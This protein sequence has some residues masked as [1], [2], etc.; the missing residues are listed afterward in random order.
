MLI[1]AHLQNGELMLYVRRRAKLSY[2]TPEQFTNEWDYVYANHTPWSMPTQ[3]DIAGNLGW[4]N[5]LF[6]IGLVMLS[7]ITNCYPPL[8]PYPA[9]VYVPPLE[10]AHL[11]DD[12]EDRQGNP[13]ADAAQYVRTRAGGDAPLP[14][15]GWD[16]DR[17]RMSANPAVRAR[18]AEH[19]A[20][21]D[22]RL[23]YDD[24]SGGRSRIPRDWVRVWSWGGFIL[25]DA[26]P[27]YRRID[28]ELRVLVAWCLCDRP[29]YR[30]RLRRLEWEVRG[31]IRRN[32]GDDEDRGDFDDDYDFG[33][34]GGG[35]GGGGGCGG[36]CG[37]PGGEGPPPGGWG[38]SDFDSGSSNS[39]IWRLRYPSFRRRRGGAGQ[40]CPHNPAP[41]NNDGG[42]GN[43]GGGDGDGG[44]GGNGGDGGDGGGGS[45]NAGGNGGG[46]GGGRGRG[47][48]GNGDDDG[49]GD[50][51]DDDDE[52]N[53]DGDHDDDD[54]DD[55]S[56]SEDEDNCDEA[57]KEW[58]TECFDRP[59]P[60]WV[61]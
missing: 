59:N 2:Y 38:D 5:N 41:N 51:D 50:G 57:M 32:W 12:D 21:D 55:D 8:P 6:Q 60:E 20:N 9:R 23:R 18:W 29:I 22:D 17:Y 35:G 45:G 3:P 24:N 40:P 26:V 58:V 56:E 47:S 14:P 10:V 30:P 39:D 34:D 27:A 4:R 42:G 46:N 31:W 19:A 52:D 15:H 54:G 44:D 16:E 33:D 25:D 36:D 49:D 43:G 13:P 61:D 28:R 53:S 48:G 1:P 7:L 11:D 37:S